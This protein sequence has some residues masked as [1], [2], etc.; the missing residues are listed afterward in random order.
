MDL[1][2]PSATMVGMQYGPIDYVGMGLH[3]FAT[4]EVSMAAGDKSLLLK[5]LWQNL[6]PELTVHGIEGL[7]KDQA[8]VL[9]TWLAD[10]CTWEVQVWDADNGGPISG[11]YTGGQAV[12]SG[13]VIA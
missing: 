8:G 9:L 3:Q 10:P 2:Q 5:P 6:A 13:N 12:P 4:S 1:R 11:V 7:D